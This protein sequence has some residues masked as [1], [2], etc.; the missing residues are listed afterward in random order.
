MKSVLTIAGSDSSGGA[1][2]QADIKTICCNK[3]YATS[4]ITSLTAQNTVKIEDIFDVPPDFL[5]KQIKCVAEDIFPNAV[6]I[7][8][9]SNEELVKVVASSIKEFNFKNVVLDPVMISTS[10]KKLLKDEAVFS[11]KEELF[12]LATLI[13]P[14]LAETSFLIDE[15]I[16]SKEK[17]QNAAEKLAKTYKTN[18]LV[19]GGHLQ[20]ESSDFLYIYEN[21]EKSEWFTSV[22]IET[23]NTHGTG[24]TLSSAIAAN[25]AKGFSLNESVK[26]AKEYLTS[27]L[28]QKLN[29]GKGNGPLMHLSI[30]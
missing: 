26:N 25:L 8:M 2:I 12:P 4:A 23:E 24:C 6:K 9:I 27:A 30:R 1:G 21:P 22:K 15:K 13:T 17:M 28:L 14:N 7:G 18:F 29:L 11:L 16:D 10:G 3:V 5:K 19:K 20:N